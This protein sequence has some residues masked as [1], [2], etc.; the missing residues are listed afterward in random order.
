MSALRFDR[1]ISH[2]LIELL[3]DDS[4]RSIGLLN[5]TISSNSLLMSSTFDRFVKSHNLIELLVDDSARPEGNIEKGGG[6]GGGGGYI[7][8]GW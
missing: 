2:N 4:A 1:I 7:G 8:F 6:G 3:V 5:P